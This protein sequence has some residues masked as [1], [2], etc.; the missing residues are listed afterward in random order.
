MKKIIK[1]MSAAPDD[2]LNEHFANQNSQ[3]THYQSSNKFFLKTMG[4]QMN[5]AD[6]GEYTRYLRNYGFLPTE[7]LNEA[8]IVLLNT[9]TVRQHAE[10][11]VYALLG[12]LKR[13]K[14]KNPENLLIV[15]GCVAQRIG[16]YLK[17]RFPYVDLVIGAKDIGLFPEL[18]KQ[19]ITDYRL[20]IADYQV[21]PAF[22]PAS[23]SA[24]ASVDKSVGRQSPDS[25][26]TQLRPP[27]PRLRWAG[28]N[29]ITA[30]V[31]IMR[32]CENFCSYCI[33][34]YVR[35]NEESRPVEEIISEIDCLVEEGVKEVTLLGQNVNSYKSY[36]KQATSYQ[37][38]TNRLSN[39][40]HETDNRKRETGFR[41]LLEEVNKIEKLERIRFVTSHPKDLDENIIY[42]MRD[43][44]KVC[45]HL[46][47]PV[48]AGSNKILERM[49]RRYRREDYLSLVEKIK[50]TIPEI[51]ITTDIIV[52]FPGETEEDFSQTLDLVGKTEFDSAYTFKYSPRPG[53][54]AGKLE[55]DVPLEVKEERLERL[56]QLCKII[57]ERKNQILVGTE[58]EVLLE[59]Y[60]QDNPEGRTRTNKIVFVNPASPAGR[61]E[62]YLL[63]KTI[64]VKITQ[65]H[66]HS[67]IGSIDYSDY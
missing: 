22:V 11:K 50:K 37:G 24:E 36:Q 20:Q 39:L 28:N 21:T 47:L 63:G 23:T 53:T 18:L 26:I 55:N 64:K 44:D 43:L 3:A 40:Q 42:A 16:E 67:L 15:A 51:A 49:N 52:G 25:P 60:D 10:D 31:T 41:E 38:T 30:F 19:K 58:Q 48:Q 4:C 5:V 12:S 17:K 35:G 65:A 66:A 29:P 61:E 59:K 46:H 45:E 13:W 8:K 57:S 33:V 32:G 6:S 1:K 2:L 62:K 56:N 9:C 34:P 54:T 7:N 14:E 27:S